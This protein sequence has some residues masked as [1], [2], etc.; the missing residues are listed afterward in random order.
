METES[1]L[2]IF[3]NDADYFIVE[4]MYS[5]CMVRAFVERALR[6]EEKS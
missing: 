6:M 4:R 3:E 5:V 2:A 1:F